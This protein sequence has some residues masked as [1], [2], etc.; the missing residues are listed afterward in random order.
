[1]GIS[2]NIYAVY[3]IK[4][5]WNGDFYQAWDDLCASDNEPKLNIIIDG[6]GNEYMVFGELLYNS[7]DARYET[8]SGE[9][10]IDIG[11]TDKFEKMK[12]DYSNKFN[13]TFPEF[14]NWFSEHEWKLHIFAH[15]S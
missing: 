7:G 11:D 12:T 14:V 2:T 1:M 5:E 4:T 15:Y 3:G 6:M 8:L 10:S 13:D 9:T